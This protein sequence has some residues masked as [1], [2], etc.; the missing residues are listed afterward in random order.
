M[1]TTL[2]GLAIAFILALVAALIGP[3]FVDWSQF[4]PQFEIEASRIVGAPVRVGGA[5]DAR[6]LPV[7]SLSLRGVSVGGP[8]DSGKVRADKLNVEFSLG[9]LM[10]GEVRATE[11]TINGG[12]LDLN[13]DDQGRFDLPVPAGRFNLGS[14]AIDR[15]NL[16]GRIALH[17]AASR[18]TLELNDI[19][20]S[21]DV[22]ALAG[23][24][25]GD[26][27]FTLAGARYPF[28][29]SSTPIPD[30]AGTRVHLTI[31]PVGQPLSVDLEGLLTFENRAPRF[32]GALLLAQPKSATDPTAT[33]WRLSSKFK[34]DPAA[35]TLEQIEASYGADDIA[36]KFTGAADI[37][38]GAAPLLRATLATK[39]IDGD[40]LAA[41][42]NAGTPLKLLSGLRQVLD[43]L[44]R[45]PVASQ[46]TLS[47]DQIMLGGR[48]VQTVTATLRG[49]AY[50]WRIDRMEAR[51]PG[52]TRVSLSSGA[53]AGDDGFKGAVDLESAEPD[54][55]A[56]WL[57]GSN[58]GAARNQKSLK[59]RG[60]VDS[61][62]A[63][64]NIDNL[65]AESDGSAVNGRIAL[66]FPDGALSRVEARLK[67][68]RLDIDPVIALARAVAGPQ[69]AWPQET[70]LSLDIGSAISAG[71]EMK[72][73]GID[74]RYGPDAIALDRLK[75]GEASG[76]MLDGNGA[77]DRK[78]ATGRLGLTA[79]AASLSRVTTLLAP[80]A[81]EFTARL[82]SAVTG[83]GPVRLKLALDLV[84]HTAQ[85]ERANLR[86]T[87]DFNAPQM[88][89]A[90]T[91]TAAP[92]L[93][94]IHGLD[95]EALGR[96]EMALD[97]KL[98]SAQ[99]RTLIAV[100]G[101]DRAIAAGEG[102]MQ[103]T[104]AIGGTWAAPLRVNA[105]ITGA[106]VD[107]DVQGTVDS[108]AEPR[109]AV[110]NLTVRRA[111]LTPL[112]NLSLAD[113]RA[114]NVSLSSRLSI[115]G[116]RYS[117]AG[118]DGVFAGARVRGRVALTMDTVPSV[119][120]E[121]GLDALDLASSFNFAIGNSG[122]AAGEPLLPGL[123]QGWRGS[124]SF[125][126]LRG[127]LPGGTE[128]RPISGAIRSDGQSL[129]IDGIKAGIGGGKMSADLDV[130][131]GLAGLALSARVQLDDADGAALRY[132][133]LALPGRAA[134]KMTLASQGRS[135]AA[136]AGALSGDGLLTLTNAQLPGLDPR[137][138][139]AAIRAGDEGRAS[140]DS[141]LRQIVETAL[142]AG[143][144]KVAAATLAIAIKDGRLRVGAT[145]VEGE[146]ARAIISGG[147]DI[148]ADQ[149]DIRTALTSSTVASGGSRPEISLF[150]T[151]TPS[152]LNRS[153]DVASLSSWLAVRAIERETRR[154]DLLEKSPPVVPTA[155]PP[156]P[157][158]PPA[159]TP[160]PAAPAAVPDAVPVPRPAPMR[161]ATPV[162]RPAALAPL[163]PA[164]DVRPAPAP[165][166]PPRLRPP[167]PLMLTPPA[168]IPTR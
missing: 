165:M 9:A 104:G 25:R 160:E 97:V 17:D 159:I 155:I 79:S 116:P 7:P 26:G 11:L 168:A 149:V 95:L 157:A 47:A 120:G 145:P 75:I 90:A 1:Q 87:L 135:A 117:F 113:P 60:D 162:Q 89:A 139:D 24:V 88:T 144:L 48:P 84:K 63:Y 122:V 133:G 40:R 146:G 121:I 164:I 148:A 10:R 131:P 23:A 36:P 51:A 161:P 127:A 56:G 64:L 119:E 14:L 109:K 151:G 126:A 20:F 65:R 35:A 142:T 32:D 8:N 44:P 37:R 45:L 66:V 140:D 141:R 132:R 99:G 166:R 12:A 71:Q 3:Y 61:G 78:A 129:T 27:N 54:V 19:A 152:G 69:A 167:P 58:D 21:G 163:P 43:D 96:T 124:L 112:L 134:L 153:V 30:S 76:V 72:P 100:L 70:I 67:G 38:I 85:P 147:Y 83:A 55:F 91:F 80:Y 73:F 4:R 93:A 28:R 82:G 130:R 138:F 150:I 41:A 2:L 101:L 6:L 115:D 31:D 110:V 68:D 118:L 13:L 107:A 59:L 111:N 29:V 39:T 50:S 102:P 77:F 53:A 158:P 16:T 128:F 49:D 52:T 33:P 106:T 86:A 18:S 156:A 57:R 22:R 5:L 105:K 15:L 108:F 114:Q 62:S 98:S 123:V 42:A 154:L 94:A 92:A 103:I 74:L 136:L 137:A 81:P 143:P 34:A 125:Q 46:I